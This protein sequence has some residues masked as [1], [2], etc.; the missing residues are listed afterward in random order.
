[1]AMAAVQVMGYDT[2]VTFAGASGYLEMN[3]YKPVMIF[4]VIQSMRILSDSSVSFAEFLVEGLEPNR[5]QI[6]R[7]LGHSLMLVTA[8]SPVI[9]YDKASKVAHHAMEK[10]LSLKDACLELGFVSSEEFDRVVD[11]YRMAHPDDD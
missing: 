5:K 8:L 10:D 3:V 11:P 4:N 6:D 9:G 2:A 1:M 7:F